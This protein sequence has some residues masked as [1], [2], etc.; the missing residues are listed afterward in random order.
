M[1]QRFVVV[2]AVAALHLAPI[3]SAFVSPSTVVPSVPYRSA[4]QSLHTA[5]AAT[6]TIPDA[7]SFLSGIFD[8]FKNEKRSNQS[9]TRVA[10]NLV[11]KLVSEEKCFT[12]SSG[13]I[14]FGEVCAEDVV[15]EDCFEVDSPFVGK[16]SVLQH[17]QNK[18]AS[19]Q[20]KG[21]LRMDRISDGSRACGFAWTYTCGD[22]EGLRGTTFVELNENNEISYVREIPEPLFKPGN[23]TLKLL[24]AVTKDAV[25]KPPPVYTQKTPTKASDIAL[26]LFKE[27]NGDLAE[28]MRFFDESIMY[29]DFNFEE[30]LEGTSEVRGFIQDF[31]FP[32]ITFKL[33]RCD[34]GIISTCFTWEVILE[35]QEQVVKGISLYEINQ[36]TKKVEYVRDIPESPTK[37][38][39]LG[40]LARKLRPGLGVFSPVNLGSRPGGK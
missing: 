8:I 5:A 7:G 20:G 29:R 10:Q 39:P 23:L 15:Y 25:P 2:A 34:D 40:N 4:R 6:A 11:K 16:E 12:E 27:V 28:S 32:G 33:D 18:V 31:S 38:P 14:A 24:E 19:R 37:P 36:E 35:G 21:E 13:A 22:Q 9:E 30:M 26:Y 3:S 17:L 1:L